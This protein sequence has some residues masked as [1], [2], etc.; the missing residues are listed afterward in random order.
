[1]ILRYIS[2]SFENVSV[3]HIKILQSIEELTINLED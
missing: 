2:N 3:F 1:M